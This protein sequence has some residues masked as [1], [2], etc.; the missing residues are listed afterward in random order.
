MLEEGDFIT[1]TCTYSAPATF[2]SSTDSEMCYFF[3]IAWPAGQLGAS[4]AIHGANTCLD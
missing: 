3:S 1:T 2:G 4:P